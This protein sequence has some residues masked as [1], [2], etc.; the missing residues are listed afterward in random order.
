MDHNS[1][2]QNKVY[3]GD[4][5]IGRIE[6]RNGTQ[7][8][9]VRDVLGTV[10]FIYIPGNFQGHQCLFLAYSSGDI[11]S[12]IFKNAKTAIKYRKYDFSKVN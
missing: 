1:E 11:H 12:A 3:A 6:Q 2:K 8:L 7:W 5:S 9:R 4:I 10:D